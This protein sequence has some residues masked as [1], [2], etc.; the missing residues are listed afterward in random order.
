MRD[1]RINGFLEAKNSLSAALNANL[2]IGTEKG[3]LK[4]EVQND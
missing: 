4:E 2:R 3:K 1:V